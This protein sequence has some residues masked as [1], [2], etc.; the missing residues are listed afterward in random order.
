MKLLPYS[1]GLV[2]ASEQELVNVF[3]WLADRHHGDYEIHQG[4]RLL[5]QWSRAHLDTLL[6]FVNR[7]GS[8]VSSDP[9]RVRSVLFCGMRVGSYG[10]LRDLQDLLLLIHQ[11]RTAWTSLAQAA[12]A[13]QDVDMVEAAMRCATETDRQIDWACSHVKFAAPQ[14]LTVPPKVTE[15]PKGSLPKIEPSHLVVG[16]I[17]MGAVGFA[18]GLLRITSRRRR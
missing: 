18:V 15:E 12:K 14:A 8:T 16:T 4:C 1:L 7:H 9:G 2:Q 11:T 10:L 5:A 6:P 13:M 3:G 17:L